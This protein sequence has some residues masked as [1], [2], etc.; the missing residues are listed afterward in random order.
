MI[1]QAITE[2]KRCNQ[3]ITYE[4]YLRLCSSSIYAEKK[5]FNLN[6]EP[7]E[8]DYNQYLAS[9]YIEIDI[10]KGNVRII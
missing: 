2:L 3:I 4:N 1:L 7:V 9:E 8:I 10:M 5:L 6:Y